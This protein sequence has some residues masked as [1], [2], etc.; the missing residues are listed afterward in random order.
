MRA[1]EPCCSATM[2]R[3]DTSRAR[4]LYN[5]YRAAVAYV[6]IETTHGDQRIGT[7]YH[8]G[9][10]IWITARHVVDGNKVLEIGVAPFDRYRLADDPFLHPGDGVD[11]AAL[12]LEGPLSSRREP[13]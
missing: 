13:V 10:G 12:L 2:L 11:V 6:A 4:E 3:M 8:V 5:K 9:E 1:S 7:A